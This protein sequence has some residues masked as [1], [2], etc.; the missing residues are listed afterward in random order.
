M[1]NILY[2]V[3]GEGAGHSTRSREVLAHLVKAGH[4]VH[5]ASFD[6]GLQNLRD[7]FDVTE[8]YGF[9]FAYVNNRVR[10]NRTI[11]KNLFT[12]PKAARS[13]HHLVK[14]AEE[15]KIDLVITDFEPLTCHVA[16]RRHLPVITIDNQH[17]L[18]NTLVSYPKEFRRDAAAA[19][20][21]CRLMTPRVDA[22]LVT[23][24]FVPKVKK[25]KTFI[26]PPILRQEIL[27][28]KP[29]EGNAILVYVT[30]PAP[31]LAKTLAGV[32]AEFIA[33]G[34]GREG[35]EANITYKKPSITGFLADLVAAK[36]II[37][38][39]GFSLVTEALHLGKP[40]LAVPVAHQFEQTFNAYWLQRM[41]YGAWWDDL[42]KE[43]VE[44]FLYNLPLYREKL[45]GYPR[46][47]NDAI[48]AKLDSLIED[49]T[50]PRK[51]AAGPR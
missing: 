40:Y 17:C 45:Q 15:W 31:A 28:A 32:R 47:G 38:N 37:A 16:H 21:V 36:A 43:R 23:S 18:T 8:I 2:G 27:S 42:N 19:K 33:Y 44:S 49:F 46:Q 22:S 34:F 51:R 6:R 29:T 1:A 25:A 10:Y 39:A 7:E 20:L 3:N 13:S 9:R 35:R 5:V 41:E 24:F 14:L 11:A 26:F 48:L 50:A 4:N 30:S 12:A